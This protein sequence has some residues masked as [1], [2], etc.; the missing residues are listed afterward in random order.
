[1]KHFEDFLLVSHKP[2]T[3]AERGWIDILRAIF[4]GEVPRPDLRRVQLMRRVMND[5]GIEAENQRSH[6]STSRLPR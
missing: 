6:P 4:P 1:M 2:L 3:E 5:L